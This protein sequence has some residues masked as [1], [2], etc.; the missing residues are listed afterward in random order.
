MFSLLCEKV[1]LLVVA[2]SMLID[3][4]GSRRLVG[5]LLELEFG[6]GGGETSKPM[7]SRSMLG[8]RGAG[9]GGAGAG[10]GVVTGANTGAD[11]GA[12]VG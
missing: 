4:K 8:V 3:P 11:T 10:A 12:G 2:G 9:T 7:S 1:E 5:G 6:G